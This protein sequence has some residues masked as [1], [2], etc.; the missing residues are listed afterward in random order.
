VETLDRLLTD[1]GIVTDFAWE[2]YNFQRWM[3]RF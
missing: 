3:Y 2:D 1:N